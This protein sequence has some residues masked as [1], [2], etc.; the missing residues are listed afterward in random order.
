MTRQE[1][2][3]RTPIHTEIMNQEIAG[4]QTGY[5]REKI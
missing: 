5:N 3:G 1:L 2:M 4:E